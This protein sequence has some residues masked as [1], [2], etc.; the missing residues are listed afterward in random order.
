VPPANVTVE[1]TPKVGGGGVPVEDLIDVKISQKRRSQVS[2][3][4]GRVLTVPVIWG[5]R[6][7]ALRR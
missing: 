7:N 1:I 2:N 3:R 4:E 5:R 6:S